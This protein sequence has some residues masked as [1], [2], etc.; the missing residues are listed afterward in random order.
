MMELVYALYDFA[1]ADGGRDFAPIECAAFSEAIEHLA[2]LMSPFTPHLAEEIWE[3]IGRTDSLYFHRWPAHDEGIAREEMVTVVVQ[4]GGKVRDR[5]EVPADTAEER[6]REFALA[7]QRVQPHIG[8]RQVQKV[9]V[10]P[11]KLVNIVV[12]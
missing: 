10:I 6:L 12:R 2:L 5:L 11:N 7:S 9:I 3:R 8:G 1:D 4:V